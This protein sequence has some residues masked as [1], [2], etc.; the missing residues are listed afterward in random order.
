[1]VEDLNA[2]IDELIRISES[3]DISKIT[4]LTGNNGSGKSLT[5]KVVASRVFEQLGVRVKSVSM[6]LRTGSRPE[7]GALSGMG[8]DDEW[9]ATS[10]NTLGILEQLFRTA[11]K[12]PEETKFI[13]LDEFEIG[14]SEETIMALVEYIN[15]ELED[16]K[17]GCLIITHSR[18]AVRDLKFDEFVNIQGLSVDE[19]LTR[20]VVPTNLDEL[21]ENKLFIALRDRLKQGGQ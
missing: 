20:K 11:R 3:I 21:K 15:K 5:R 8:R 6:D 19:W 17:I 7:F 10:I 16:L 12:Y 2:H 4:I 18:A 9:I 1:M 14:C 13:I